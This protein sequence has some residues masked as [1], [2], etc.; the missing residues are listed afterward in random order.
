MIGS[1][2]DAATIQVKTGE[3]D[4]VV[5]DTSDIVITAAADNMA[6]I[7]CADA[8]YLSEPGQPR[9]PWKVV[10][11]LLPPN[12]DLSTVAYKVNG[13]TYAPV[14]GNYDLEPSPLYATWDQDG[15]PVVVIPPGRTIVDGYD[16]D[17]YQ[18][19]E[20]WPQE[21]AKISQTGE[22]RQWKLAEVAVPLA[23]YNPVTGSIQEVVAA[24]INVTF[25]SSKT[26]RGAGAVM[27]TQ[28]M[29]RVKQLTVNFDQG[30]TAYGDSVAQAAT[31]RSETS[32]GYVI[33]T[34]DD[35]VSASSTLDDFVAHKQGLG[36]NVQ[37]ATGS[38]W[39]GGTGTTA[40]SN[41]LTWLENNYLTLDVLY[42]LL[43]GTPYTD[44]GTVPMLMYTD[45][46]GDAP[47]DFFYSSFDGDVYWEVVVGR[48][49]YYGDADALDAVLQ[50]AIDFENSTITGWHKNVLLPMGRLDDSTP[51][52]Q[53]GEQIISDVLDPLSITSDRIYEQG[54]GMAP[55]YT[56][57]EAPAYIMDDVWN[58]EAYGMVFWITHGSQTLAQYFIDTSDCSRLNA[59]Y[60]SIVYQGSCLNAYPENS[61]NLAYVILQTGG[62]VTVAATRESYYNV[63]QTN[64]YAEGS[65]GTLALRYIGYLCNNG[66]SA[67]LGWA[68]V[69]QNGYT[70][71]PNRYRMNL[72]GDPSISLTFS[73]P[74]T[75]AN[76]TAF[77][78]DGGVALTW[79]ESAPV[80]NIYSSST[81]GGV[82]SLVASGVKAN[83]YY[84][85]GLTNGT[86]RYYVVTGGIIGTDESA[87]SD[88]VSATP[89]Q[90]LTALYAFENNANDSSVNGANAT[91][92][93]SPV[94]ST[95]QIDQAIYLDGSDDYM[96]LP[97]GAAIGETLTVATWV[98]WNGGSNWQRIFDF[99][100]GETEYMLLT[101]A[102]GGGTLRF[103]MSV[104]GYS[105]EERIEDSTTLASGE[106]VHV[107]V[108]LD[109]ATGT[110]YV[111]G[112]AAGTNTAMTITPASFL[113]C[114]NYVGASQFTADPLFAGYIDDF[115]VYSYALSAAE[116]AALASG[117]TLNNAPV[118][119]DD[120]DSVDEDG[121]VT[122][123]VLANDS[124]AD[125]DTLSVAS[126]TQGSNGAVVNN[127]TDVT[128]TPDSNFNGSDSFTCTVSDGNGGTDSATVTVTVNAVNDAPYWISDPF[129]KSSATE[130][131]AY[132]ATIA[133]D[134][135]DVD[136]GDSLSFSKVSGSSWLSVASDGTLSGTPSLSDVGANSFTV[137][138]TDAASASD[139]ATLNITVVE[140]NNPPVASNDTDSVD[141]DGSVT[142]D[143]LAND[144]D[145][146][147]DTLSVL[148]VT[149]GSNGA[150]VNNGTDATYTPNSN[151]NGSDT[152]TYVVSDGNGGTDSA[153]VNVTVN[154]VNDAP[155]F[156]SDPISKADATADSAYSGATLSGE[157]TDGDGDSLSYSKVSGAD[158]LSV[159]S[160]GALSG[161]PAS[162]DE[163]VNAFTVQ[164]SD[165]NGGTDTATL[166][167]TVNAA[168]TV[169]LVAYYEFD[170][171][172]TD[173]E[174]DNDGT[175]A[176]SPSYVTGMV[177]QAIDFDGSDDAVTLPS[178]VA[179]HDDITIAAWINWDGGSSWQRIFDF[180]NDSTEYMF[181]TPSS[182]GSTLRFAITVD[183]YG[184]EQ[185]VETSAISTGEWVHVAVTLSGD[186][187]TLYVDGEAVATNTS[188]TLDPTDFSPTANYIGQSQ[189]SA[190]PLYDGR[191][192]EFRI[193]NYA[194]AAS[195]I[196][197]L[198]S[199]TPPNN[200]PVFT[201]DP[202][203]GASATEDVAYSDTLDGEATDVDGDTLTYSKV[204]GPDWLSVASDG[205]L[206]GTP[207]TDDVGENSFIVQVDD[208][209]G[210][211]DTATLNI[212]V[213]QAGSGPVILLQDGFESS[214]DLWTDSGSTDWDRTTAQ[215]VSGSYSAHCG[216]SDNDLIS[217]NL[218]T[219]GYST[220]T[221]EF[222]YRDDDID[223]RDNVYLQLYNG[224]SYVNYY[225]LG[226][227][228]ED[229]WH[230][231]TATITAS[232]YFISN[233]RI[234]F[235]GSSIDT[236]E[237]L[238]ID[239]VTITAE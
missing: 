24:D 227:S 133:D 141:E 4:A 211:T 114:K 181:L 207:G 237:N 96:T 164:V 239:D 203:T 217:D 156:T 52:Y 91:V 1:I 73:A 185:I 125:E 117:E 16:A 8:Q 230:Q 112:S 169:G 118:A 13:I 194:L 54:F 140:Y 131:Q 102:S 57:S 43:I 209:N 23:R 80:Y 37:I 95:G 100:N 19:D 67:G 179:D 238:W 81:S 36:W 153:T 121:S 137:R 109:G 12:A 113:P 216:S 190:D 136:S 26:A 39:G 146:D 143:V 155:T 33:I 224:T 165:G 40:Y 142:I 122:I 177:G 89:Q 60:P 178:G 193:Y 218:D 212:T 90:T 99:G 9:I 34:T 56:Y 215:Y 220:I 127:G 120:A 79:D 72:Y 225:E 15:N 63:A 46:G 29:G 49:P 134:A 25:T 233:F 221:I 68:N 171:D 119:V 45:A 104:S 6:S 14:D 101:P 234:K 205:A 58:T 228:T 55:E 82:Y 145:A 180:G 87:Y 210:G 93:G 21:A 172:A 66:E 188:M 78:A 70:Y 167:I 83:R 28:Q 123:D 213:N 18:A 231:Y 157:A 154:A 31:E 175:E 187:G 30:I 51:M 160:D 202:I 138:V 149:Q 20:Y 106:W 189:F 195:E 108:T 69:R 199:I 71:P 214:F 152:F 11:V 17:I 126:V 148:S 44:T 147:E 132:S 176:G 139:D 42:V 204:S 94:Y 198:A 77:P 98:K 111:N 135:S 64:F 151:Y 115:R 173:G 22:L 168:S 226:N 88:E 32:T 85:S 74:T 159:A 75:P 223:D 50:R 144:S 2:A 62:I 232:Q 129:S 162:S 35:I 170:G 158:W 200:A 124:D 110:L 184:N 219:S 206:S 65:I 107:A 5:I 10:T 174:G 192:D 128:Y 208:G 3:Q 59:D 196:A 92:T 7:Q 191:V 201:N 186:T 86:T 229:T 163:G 47:T 105:S 197:T 182:S 116:V 103:A 166:N 97:A 48:I 150:V 236:G 222:W 235:E 161:T 27:R 38:D 61:S 84:V 130:D 183:S 41:I 76:L 53:L